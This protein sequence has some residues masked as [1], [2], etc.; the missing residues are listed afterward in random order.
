MG[1]IIT[2]LIIIGFIA[3]V[4]GLLVLVNNR[5]KKAEVNKKTDVI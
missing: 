3:G 5:D 1:T 4:V 2:A